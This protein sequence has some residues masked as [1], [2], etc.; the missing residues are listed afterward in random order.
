MIK[1]IRGIILSCLS[2]VLSPIAA[3]AVN[4]A[5]ALA[6]QN[7]ATIA[8]A[9]LH[10]RDSFPIHAAYTACVDWSM[11]VVPEHSALRVF[12]LVGTPCWLLQ[13]DLQSSR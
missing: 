5:H 11:L 10:S 3:P 12:L 2:V 1:C 13:L 4:R 6:K 7:F 9:V 8:H